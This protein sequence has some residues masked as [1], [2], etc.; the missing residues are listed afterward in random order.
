M[1]KNHFGTAALNVVR[2]SGDIERQKSKRKTSSL[3]VT[4][5]VVND[6]LTPFWNLLKIT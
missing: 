2:T 6:T 5:S 3:V 1:K 4:A